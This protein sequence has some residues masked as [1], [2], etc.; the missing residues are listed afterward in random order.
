MEGWFLNLFGKRNGIEIPARDVEVR[1]ST[2]VTKSILGE[3]EETRNS[4]VGSN[5]GEKRPGEQHINK[6]YETHR[7]FYIKNGGWESGGNGACI[8]C[9]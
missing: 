1:K 9:D 2:N 7:S 5:K 3:E 6:G 4:E 8:E